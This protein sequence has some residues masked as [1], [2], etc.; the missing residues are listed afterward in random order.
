MTVHTNRLDMTLLLRHRRIDRKRQITQNSSS[1]SAVVPVLPPQSPLSIPGVGLFPAC[2]KKY[3]HFT[4][5]QEYKTPPVM[6]S[7]AILSTLGLET[8]DTFQGSA[9]YIHNWLS[10]L[11]NDNK[12]IVSASSKADKAVSLIMAA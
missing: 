12:F 5:L 1:D 2:R 7:A 6:G 4:F 11:K 9:A 8:A 3:T 10:V